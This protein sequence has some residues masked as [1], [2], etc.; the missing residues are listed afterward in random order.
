M[1]KG[2]SIHIG[3][4]HLDIKHYLDPELDLHSCINDAEYM[5]TIAKKE[6]KEPICGEPNLI[7]RNECATTFAFIEA[8]TEAAKGSNKLNSGD[9]L[10]ITVSGHG[11]KL[12][13]YYNEEGDGRVET[14]CLYDRQF[15]GKEIFEQLAKFDYGVR[16]LVISDSCFSGTVVGPKPDFPFVLIES[17]LDF[18]INLLQSRFLNLKGYEFANYND[19]NWQR[20]KFMVEPF[21]EVT[22]DN[23]L[24]NREKRN[25][26]SIT[27]QLSDVIYEKQANNIDYNVIQKDVKRR[28]QDRVN[29]ENVSDYRE[30][31]RAS[32]IQLSACQDWQTT[33][34]GD[35]TE[36]KFSKFTEV[37]KLV[38]EKNDF[39]NYLELHQT[40]W[41]YFDSR[42]KK[43]SD[44]QNPNYYKI[45]S[46]NPI[47]EMEKPFSI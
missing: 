26:K 4:D 34:P 15:L 6:F 42:V 1:K 11:G 13:D 8:M 9:T 16:I 5:A 25:I 12:H 35:G 45:G 43:L 29:N 33:A 41:E 38:F 40:L 47:F 31:L 14:W 32:V 36:N 2:M 44:I 10:L 17:D 7:L 19:D 28:L 22:L 24:K 3:L 21:D 23:K 30:L 46:P 37:L 39:K 20:F 27:P 18:D